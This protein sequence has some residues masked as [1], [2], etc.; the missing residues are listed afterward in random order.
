MGAAPT[1]AAANIKFIIHYS[2]H[3][4]TQIQEHSRN[5]SFKAEVVSCKRKEIRYQAFPEETKTLDFKGNLRNDNPK[6]QVNASFHR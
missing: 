4:H 6:G 2:L 3:A 1:L 5:F